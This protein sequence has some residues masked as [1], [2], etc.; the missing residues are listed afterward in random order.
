MKG[1]AVASVADIEKDL[2]EHALA[3]LTRSISS[4]RD[5]DHSRGPLFAVVDVAV[6]IEALLKARL[7]REHWSLLLSNPDGTT[8]TDFNTGQ[9]KTVTPDK[10]ISRL[11]KLAG[12]DLQVNKT[13]VT[14]VLNLR[15]RTVHFT[16]PD[17]EDS[18][19]VQANYGRALNAALVIL[20]NEFRGHVQEELAKRI[21]DVVE[22]IMGEVGE[23][24]SL[25]ERRMAAIEIVLSGADFCLKCPRCGQVAL[26]FSE[27]SGEVGCAFCPWR[28]E[29]PEEA[30]SEYLTAVMGLIASECGVRSVVRRR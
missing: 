24:E 13:D 23:I 12:V 17:D 26:T 6:A 25:V 1:A 11:E 4:F 14:D 3:F 29:S 28:P 9:A 21:S 27:A 2:T 30:A 15:N 7:A 5:E 22:Q 16:V 8:V 18:I 19:G 10:A 20:E